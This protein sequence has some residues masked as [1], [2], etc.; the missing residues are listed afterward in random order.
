MKPA[1]HTCV[2]VSHKP[3]ARAPV[4]GRAYNLEI[5]E[6]DGMTISQEV[7]PLSVGEDHSTTRCP[8]CQ[9]PHGSERMTRGSYLF[10]FNKPLIV[11]CCLATVEQDALVD[12]TDICNCADVWHE[13]ERA[14]DEARGTT[15]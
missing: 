3:H 10:S 8:S 4:L 1:E 13:Q 11:R 12:V 5:Q 7:E 6:N 9:H 2:R 15:S 14:D